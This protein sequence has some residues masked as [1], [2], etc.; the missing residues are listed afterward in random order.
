MSLK[1]YTSQPAVVHAIQYD[2]VD[3]GIVLASV[4]ALV[5]KSLPKAKPKFCPTTAGWW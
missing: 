2:G 4:K 3:I 5:S 1:Q